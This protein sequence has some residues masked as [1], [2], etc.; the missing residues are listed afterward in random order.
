MRLSEIL[1]KE[2]SDNFIQIESF[3]NGRNLKAG[4]Q[5]KIEIG[6]I[7][8]NF[9]CTNCDNL[10]TFWSD[11]DI[12]CLGVDETT[13]SIDI[14]LKCGCGNHIQVWFLVESERSIYDYAPLVR[15]IKKGIRLGDNAKINIDCYGE[16]SI[17]IERADLAYSEGLGAGAMVY[18]RMIFEQVT[19]RVANEMGIPI[20][21]AN[22]RRKNFWTLLK[23]VD[24]T[25]P[26]IPQEFKNNRYKLFKELSE[27][28]HGNS[29]E[30]QALMKYSPSRRLIIGILDNIKN[31]AE[32]CDALLHF[33]WED[34]E[35]GV[36]A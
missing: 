14:N 18:L 35:S 1:S 31:N 20:I 13:I 25:Q 19:K 17:L 32:I 36:G 34:S 16:E 7:G 28:V 12:Y 9:H 24:E 29:N 4:K 26:I 11:K 27:I 15:V 3:M 23:E 2:P 5:R 33:D 8:L 10:R 6:T 22:N 30:E 21:H